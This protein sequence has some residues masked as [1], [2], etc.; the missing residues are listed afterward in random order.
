MLPII[1]K[2]LAYVTRDD[3]LLVFTE[4]CEGRAGAGR[5]R[6]PSALIRG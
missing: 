4:P 1:D 5:G 2:V 3:R 6:R